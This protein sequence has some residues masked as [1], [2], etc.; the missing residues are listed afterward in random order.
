MPLVVQC[1]SVTKVVGCA[2][3]G[4][5]PDGLAGCV[6]FRNED[7]VVAA[8][9]ERGGSDVQG[10]TLEMAGE[11]TV[12]V[13]IDSDRLATLDLLPPDWMGPLEFPVT[14]ELGQKAIEVSA[15]DEFLSSKFRL[16]RKLAGEVDRT[17]L[18]DRQRSGLV[19]FL[20]TR[21][22]RPGV[23]GGGERQT[24]DYAKQDRKRGFH[25]RSVAGSGHSG[26]LIWPS[27]RWVNTHQTDLKF[28][29]R[30]S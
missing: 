8:I 3:G 7:I 10:L 29:H 11:I 30:P 24:G 9:L 17:I 18:P 15:G 2:T 5:R 13:C 4:G 28:L 16:L 12:P 1:N 27:E 20:A 22:K 6:E 26:I 21:L 14:V 19:V 23:F 25:R